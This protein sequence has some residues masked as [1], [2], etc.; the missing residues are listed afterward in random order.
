MTSPRK[1]EAFEPGSQSP[2]PSTITFPR[3]PFFISMAAGLSV[4]VVVLAALSAIV[5][6]GG[7]CQSPAADTHQETP[8]LPLA[9]S[10]A[11]LAALVAP[12]AVGT[13][14]VS[15]AFEPA[16]K[17][18]QVLDTGRFVE[19]HDSVMHVVVVG[20]DLDTFGHLHPEDFGWA[21]PYS[22]SPAAAAGGA[23]FPLQLQLP[24]AG[25][26]LLG[27]EG[28]VKDPASSSGAVR[29]FHKSKRVTAAG[30]SRP[31]AAV[32]LAADALKTTRYW[33]PTK[34]YGTGNA[35]VPM[36]PRRLSELEVTNAAG[37]AAAAD[38]AVEV[39]M[40][41]ALPSTTAPA[42]RL[43]AGHPYDVSFRFRHANGTAVTDLVDFL[44]AATHLVIV[45]EGLSY[46]DHA[47]A[48]PVAAA[49]G[50]GGH[51]GHGRRRRLMAGHAGHGGAGGGLFG[52]SVVASDVVFPVEGAYRVIGQALRSGGDL[53]TFS[54]SVVVV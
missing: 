6:R 27:F 44:D 34:W 50:A 35:S 47:H 15:V 4:V 1:Y 51:A 13:N 20:E 52:P 46:V 5:A 49:A 25:D 8:E 17:P 23:S 36:Q 53:V 28:M 24:W 32:D 21:P 45:R 19:E 26:Y 16:A 18:G 48:S 39:S 33:R 14:A 2:P 41:V 3:R 12:M 30:G 43:V 42:A 40:V 54:F 31:P 29:P 9:F 10:A 38:G 37:A 7:H 11:T 22:G